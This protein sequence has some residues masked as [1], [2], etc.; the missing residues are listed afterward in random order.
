MS[1][2]RQPTLE[3]YNARSQ[4]IQR[5]TN[6][7]LFGSP[8]VQGSVWTVRRD[9]VKVLLGSYAD[10][11][12]EARRLR[13]EVRDSCALTDIFL[14]EVHRQ[15]ATQRTF[16]CRPQIWRALCALRLITHNERTNDGTTAAR[17]ENHL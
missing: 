4:A 16:K 14:E 7:A 12:D 11:R 8:V 17:Q 9:D 15:K 6:F 13:Q 1:H 3:Q 2:T 10:W 5:L